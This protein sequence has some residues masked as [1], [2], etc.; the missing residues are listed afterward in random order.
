MKSYQLIGTHH[1]DQTVLDIKR[2]DQ[3]PKIFWR[4]VR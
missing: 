3:K 4:A 2:G 1:D